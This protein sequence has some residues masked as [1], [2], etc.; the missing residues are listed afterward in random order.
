VLNVKQCQCMDWRNMRENQRSSEEP[1]QSASCI[2]SR[3]ENSKKGLRLDENTK[4]SLRNFRHQAAGKNILRYS[5]YILYV[6]FQGHFCNKTLALLNL[7]LKI[8][9][10]RGS[11]GFYYFSYIISTKGNPRGSGSAWLPEPGWVYVNLIARHNHDQGHPA[12][13]SHPWWA[14]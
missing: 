4:K 1:K 5:P 14:R 12:R 13:T 9:K 8:S 11:A 10:S 2:Q 7:S 3:D 6:D